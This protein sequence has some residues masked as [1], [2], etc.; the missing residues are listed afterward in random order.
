M[1]NVSNDFKN[2]IKRQVIRS[3]LRIN[4]DGTNFN[5]DY[6]LQGS[7]S[8]TNQCSDSSDVTL[9]AVYVGELT[10][11]FL[12]GIPINR[13]TWKSRVI[14][15]YYSLKLANDSYEEIPLGVY[16]V[17]EATYSMS[18]VEVKAYDYMARFDKKLVLN[19]SAGSP[20]SFLLL[21][22]RN[23]NVQ[24]GMT[25]LDVNALPNGSTALVFD[26]KNN[27]VTT[28]RDMLYRIAQI[29]GG[30]ATIDRQG[31]LVVKTYGQTSVDTITT[32][33]RFNTAKFSDYITSYTGLSYTNLND[34]S[35]HYYGATEDTGNVINLGSNPF[36]QSGTKVYIDGIC[37]NILSAIGNITYTPFE[38]GVLGNPAYDL[39]DVLT[40]VDGL[41]GTTSSCCVMKYTFK[42]HDSFDMEG[43]G[44]NPA[45]ASAK[46]K[47]DKNIE[48][49]IDR[50][51]DN[52]VIFTSFTNAEEIELHN[53]ETTIIDIH[54][55]SAK[56]SYVVFQA[57]ILT[58]A[59]TDVSGINYDDITATVTYIQN[60]A[61]IE[62]YHPTQT[63]TD[64][65]H[66]ISLMYVIP[67]ENGI[68]NHWAVKLN[69]DGGT[70][71]I[72]VENIKATIYGQGLVATEEWDGLLNFEDAIPNI[73]M[74]SMSITAIGE[75]LETMLINDT[76]NAFS[77]NIQ[78]I[79]LSGMTITSIS[80]FMLTELTEFM[81]VNSTY[82]PTYDT[83]CVEI[84]NDVFVVIENADTPQEMTAQILN[85]EIERVVGLEIEATN[86]TL[87]F[88]D[89]GTTWK[90]YN[91]GWAETSTEMTTSQAEALTSEQWLLLSNDSIYAKIS[92][93]VANSTFTSLKYT[94]VR[95]VE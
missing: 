86:V 32:D 63:L 56:A 43:F 34:N 85:T 2:S 8:I 33:R 17:D 7:F 15:P 24:L 40:C 14:R 46:S 37:N 75:A 61:E 47:V 45:L 11:T 71:Y 82:P 30:F 16:A 20:Y 80:D 36:L 76:Q 70:L 35:T 66:I 93:N 72:D 19:Q 23:C 51:K 91:D 69:V 81:L 41:A 26:L 67:V 38:V 62:T 79:V 21:I 55:A 29:L 54:F 77:E 4:I 60:E 89:D 25:E 94:Y 90:S 84:D 50:T 95:G 18:G 49:L 48:G 65:K 42:Y 92:L 88:S 78:D 5:D 13:N 58:N 39:G 3:R 73:P 31:R 27:D 22:C 83:E 87:Q 12:K 44:K 9:G 1:Y 28:Y 68:I 52:E 57:E 53:E 64:G 74:Q 6:I 10:C 59:S